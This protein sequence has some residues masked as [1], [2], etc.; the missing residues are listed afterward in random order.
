M[1]FLNDGWS[2]LVFLLFINERF[3]SIFR[4]FNQQ[5]QNKSKWFQKSSM[6]LP[7]PHNINLSGPSEYEISKCFPILD[8]WV[9]I[10]YS[11]Q[12]RLIT[13]LILHHLLN[14]CLVEIYRSLER[15][16]FCFLRVWVV[17]YLKKEVCKSSEISADIYQWP[18]RHW[19]EINLRVYAYIT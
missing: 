9:S 7:F 4:R 15:R 2:L 16:S 5:R 11:S 3:A 13:Y 17:K 6:H 10:I 19:R 14:Q 12:V 8:F 18:Q 1:Q